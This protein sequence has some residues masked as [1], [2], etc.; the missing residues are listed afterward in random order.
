MSAARTL[1]EK[2]WD[3]HVIVKRGE[4][5]ALL[6]VDRN[7]IHEGSFHAFKALEAERH[8]VRKPRQSFSVVDHYAPTR[9]R[10][11]GLAGIVASELRRPI[12][13]LARNSKIHGITHFGL[14]DPRQG[15]VHVIGPQLGWTQPGLVIT[16]SDSHT[17]T[18]GAFGALA[19]GIGAS[20]LKQILATQCLWQKKPRTMLITI[21]GLLRK[22]VSSKDIILAIIGRIGTAG[23][24]SHVI[25]Y[26][27]SG[28]RAL[29]MDERMTV[30]NMS[31]EAGARA[32]MI[33]PDDT[34][35]AYLEGREYAP[36]GHNWDKALAYWRSLPS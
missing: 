31:I 22:G 8:S 25:E 32:G 5:D 28:I 7:L 24:I 36:S 34:T 23:A 17:A 10:A 2:I 18:H 14:D 11:Q 29:G 35:Y 15:I 20:Q 9:N 13:L 33:A 6:Y 27:G 12:E 19:I 4:H 30:C 16:C 26:A 3:R 1:F 21:N